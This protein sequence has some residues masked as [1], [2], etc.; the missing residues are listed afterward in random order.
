MNTKKMA[1]TGNLMGI[2]LFLGSW[3]LLIWVFGMEKF[4]LPSPLSVMKIF[5]ENWKMLLESAWPTLQ[6]IVYGFSLSVCVGI[7]LAV[8][9]VSYRRVEQL[10]SP[11]LIFSQTIPKVAIAPLFVIWFGFGMLP[12]ILIAFLI[13]FFPIVIDTS[14]GL[15]SVPQDMLDLVASTGGSFWRSLRKVRLPHALPNIF[16]GLKLA[17]TFATIGAIVGEFVGTSEGLGYVIQIANG[18][19]QTSL[20]F[21]AV[22]LLSIMGL[23]LYNI[24]VLL[25]KKLIPWHI[26]QH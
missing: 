6:E 13:S 21:A 23:L 16:G 26:S 25:E 17:I 24:V 2:V 22:I 1:I 19:L 18:R 15:K 3:Q 11:I 8:I 12:K 7:P 4:V 20:V 5:L 14:V 9:M 10:I